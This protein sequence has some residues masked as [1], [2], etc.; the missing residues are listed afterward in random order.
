MRATGEAGE[1]G[2]ARSSASLDLESLKDDPSI[3]EDIKI[4]TRLSFAFYS[5][6]SMQLPHAQHATSD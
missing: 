2:E 6:V 4:K 3:S 1:A 5:V